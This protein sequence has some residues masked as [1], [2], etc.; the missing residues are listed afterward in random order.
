[1]LNFLPEEILNIIYKK[2]FN[3]VIEELQEDIIMDEGKNYPKYII[4]K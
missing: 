4:N 2:I 3:E 1:M